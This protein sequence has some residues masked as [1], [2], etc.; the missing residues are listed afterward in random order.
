MSG[1]PVCLDPVIRGKIYS[2]KNGHNMCSECRDKGN[3]NKCPIYR[4]EG[5][6][7]RNTWVEN[8]LTTVSHG[9]SVKCGRH[10]KGCP[11]FGFMG[12]QMEIHEALC[13]FRSF[14][15]PGGLMRICKCT[16][17]TLVELLQ[18][19]SDRRGECGVVA[20]ACGPDTNT[21]D[22]ST[23][24]FVQAFRDTVPSVFAHSRQGRPIVLYSYL[25]EN[26]APVLFVQRTEI[27][28]LWPISLDASSTTKE[29]GHWAYRVT[30]L[31]RKMYNGDIQGIWQQGF[32][33]RRCNT[34]IQRFSAGWQTLNPTT[35]SGDILNRGDCLTL[36]DQQVLRLRLD[37][38][39]FFAAIE[40]QRKPGRSG[41]FPGVGVTL[42][43]AHAAASAA[44]ERR[45]RGDPQA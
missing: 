41:L 14:P 12:P 4:E 21:A 27:Q 36:T 15:C 35:S 1:C 6:D 40:I 23:S 32:S 45:A 31:S 13:T 5:V 25:T 3:L 33:E 29:K 44:V 26:L 42:S 38:I 43:S 17:S 9:S 20:K 18:H 37:N 2:C 28:G 22:V 30:I 7:N 39:L 10:E 19:L 8:C 11:A 34:S 24:L 16:C